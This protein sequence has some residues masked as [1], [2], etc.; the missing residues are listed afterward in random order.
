MRV[1]VRTFRSAVAGRPEGLH[2]CAIPGLA[3]ATSSTVRMRSISSFGC[4]A[5]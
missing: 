1:V 3:E 5:R 2:Y 4:G